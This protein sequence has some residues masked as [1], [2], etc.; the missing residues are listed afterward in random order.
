M[1]NGVRKKS[2]IGLKAY[3][4]IAMPS[5]KER[6]INNFSRRADAYHQHNQA[7]RRAGQ[8][9]IAIGSE[10]LANRPPAR[11]LEIG[12]GDGYL[13]ALLREAFPH[14]HLTASDISPAM[15]ETAQSNLSDPDIEWC[16]MDGENPDASLPEYDAIFCNMGVQ[17][18]TDLPKAYTRWRERLLN[19]DGV[20]FTTRPG[21]ECFAVWRQ[22]LKQAKLPSGMI[23]FQPSSFQVEKECFSLDYGSSLGFLKQMRKSGAATPHIDYTP[24]SPASLTKACKICDTLCDGKIE[25]QIVYDVIRA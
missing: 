21:P 16:L 15:L 13:T 8:H 9:L 18:F 7:Q 5:W 3:K 14:A 20:A 24:L 11:I 2:T 17:W 12:C 25:W 19:A 22:A 1:H 4:I 10:H 6:V 23:P